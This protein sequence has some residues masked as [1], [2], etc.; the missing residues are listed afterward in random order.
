VII[1]GRRIGFWR[2][3]FTNKY[4]RIVWAL[5]EI[6]KANMKKVFGAQSKNGGE[7]NEE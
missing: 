6:Y 3:L 7:D 4:Q 1:G 2:Y 5:K